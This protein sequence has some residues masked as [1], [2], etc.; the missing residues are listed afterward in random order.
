MNAVDP[1]H[2]SPDQRSPDERGARAR[3]GADPVADQDQIKDQIADSLERLTTDDVS[4]TELEQRID[5]SYAGHLDG[6]T[7][8][9]HVP[10]LAAGE[11]RTDLHAEGRTNDF[12]DF[13]HRS[14]D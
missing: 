12:T 2:E 13:A 3:I 6:A 10:T 14:V 4:R 8:T 11:V 9:D 7:I 5:E 1:K